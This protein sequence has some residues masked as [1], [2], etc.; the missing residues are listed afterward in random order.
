MLSWY[1]LHVRSCCELR[2]Q[3]R[4]TDASIENL[5]PSYD[6]V[7]PRRNRVLTRALF[8]GYV[9]ARLDLSVTGVFRDSYAGIHA[10]S[11][12]R[13]P[14]LV[15]IVGTGGHALP[16]DDTEIESV[17]AISQENTAR[18]YPYLKPESRVKIRLGIAVIEGTVVELKH[19]NGIVLVVVSLPLFGRSICRDVPL[20]DLELIMK[21]ES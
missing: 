18:P 11:L 1:A 21:G 16:L 7:S 2:V 19:K 10:A 12:V 9:F 20:S 13:V 5:Y 3:S 4:L 6:T 8:P 17:R 15:G 14:E